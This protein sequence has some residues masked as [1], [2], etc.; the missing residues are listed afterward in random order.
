MLVLEI[1]FQG[2]VVVHDVVGD[3]GISDIAQMPWFV[4][5]ASG[6]VSTFRVAENEAEV[7]DVRVDFG[8]VASVG[9]HFVVVADFDIVFRHDE[10]VD[11]EPGVVFGTADGGE[12]L[13]AV[14]LAVGNTPV[15]PDFLLLFEASIGAI[16]L[17]L[18]SFFVEKA[19]AEPFEG[20]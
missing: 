3:Y 18:D 19:G 6:I 17:N 15:I 20:D 1:F 7:G 9:N 2:Q 4:G 11:C 13:F 16:E 8:E 5:I 14:I 12:I 10:D